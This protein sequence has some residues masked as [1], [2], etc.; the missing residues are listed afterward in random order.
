MRNTIAVCIARM[1]ENF[2]TDALKSIC[3][4][5]SEC[6]FSVQVYNVFE[7]L[8]ERDLYDKGEESI[9]ELINYGRLCGIILFYEKI[10]DLELNK[11]LIENGKANGLPVVCVDRNM[12]GCYSITFDYAN[13]FE[14]IVRHLIEKHQCKTFFMMAGFRN[15]TFSD[16]RIEV[17][18]R[19]LD[20]YGLRLTADDIGYG[21]FWEE[22]CRR[23]MHEFLESKRPLPDA[24]IAAN[25]TMAITICTEL[26]NAGYHVPQDTIVTG[27][28]GI[29][30]ERY[31]VPR[32]TTAQQNIEQ[33]GESAVDI[34]DRIRRGEP[35]V[36]KHHMIP[37]AI[38][39]AQSCGC[40]PIVYNSVSK[41]I[42]GLYNNL[43]E[44]RQ[45][46]KFMYEM[47]IDMTS[48]KTIGNMI[49]Y[50]E[51]YIPYLSGYHHIYVCVYKSI[52]ADDEEMIQRIELQNMDCADAQNKD[53]VVLCEW[54]EKEGFS[55]PL[56]CYEYK[57]QLPDYE[58]IV[59]KM[60][61]VIF[62]PLHMQ[63]TVFGYMAFDMDPEGNKYY[64]INNLSMNL[65][66]C[67]DSVR[68]SLKT[69]KINE[70]LRQAND[71]LEEL[72]IRDSLTGIYNRRG[73][74]QEL[75]HKLE[76]YAYGWLM[77]VSID[78]DGLKQINDGYGHSEGDYAIKT[79]GKAVLSSIEGCG[80]CARFGGDEFAAALFFHEYEASVEQKFKTRLDAYLEQINEKGQKPYRISASC[81]TKVGTIDH[82]LDL[83][84]LL[85]EADNRMYISKDEHHSRFRQNSR[86]QKD[87]RNLP[88]KN[89]HT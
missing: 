76:E 60:G 85:K 4:R 48:K 57:E 66:H 67:M 61:H 6:G 46:S 88:E 21:D 65:G 33:S 71:K 77:M 9:F 10:K 43:T 28:D 11:R 26:E 68:Q 31:V 34:I 1:D 59:S 29:E 81:G 63:D 16:E 45:F 84:A 52:L 70:K 19:V 69:R 32:L 58:N 39:Y 64:Q 15:N 2:Q 83:D 40:Q 5:A 87:D 78:L 54:H 7:E 53:M 89:G 20:E 51:K 18:R 74:Y 27:F 41:Q 24:F 44:Y 25:D 49:E 30:M 35:G 42:S 22:P 62:I 13:S 14:R 86:N 38:R 72:Y 75:S 47:I 79:V 3:K 55:V 23:V 73:F 36:E 80:I 12:Q 37:F 56:T 82:N 17:V 50:L 8:A